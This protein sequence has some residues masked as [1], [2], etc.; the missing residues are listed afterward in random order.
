ML[1]VNELEPNPQSA[2]HAVD[3]VCLLVEGTYPF[4]AGGVSAWVHDIIK[5]HGEL[6]FSIFNIG[7]NASAY[8]APCYVLPDHV[9]RL[10][11]VYCSEVPTAPLSG[12]ARAHL[13]NEIRALSR[14]SRPRRPSRVLGAI[15]R[16]SLEPTVVDDRLLSDL[17]CG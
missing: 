4:V 1:S 7:S 10:Q 8:G 2:A 13:D 12:P 16:L 3:D 17:V 11:Q 9:T 6:T 14:G 15:R 5:G